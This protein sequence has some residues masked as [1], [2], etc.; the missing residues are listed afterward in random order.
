MFN[1]DLNKVLLGIAIVLVVYLLGSVLTT[2]RVSV[3][4]LQPLP[5]VVESAKAAG[6]S[7]AKPEVVAPVVDEVVVPAEA[8]T[9]KAA[10]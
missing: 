2:K 5:S 10:D 6:A 9:L 1:L 7:V 4:H 8:P 3:P